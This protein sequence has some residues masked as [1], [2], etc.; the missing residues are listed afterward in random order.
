MK[1]NKWVV[2]TTALNYLRYEIE[3]EI[4]DSIYRHSQETCIDCSEEVLRQLAVAE[5]LGIV[6]KEMMML[7]DKGETN[8]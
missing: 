8:D 7:F 5:I 1:I 3:V 4:G 6:R 2:S